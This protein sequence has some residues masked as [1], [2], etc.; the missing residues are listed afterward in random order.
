[1]PLFVKDGEVYRSALQCGAGL[2]AFLEF[3]LSDEPIDKVVLY[4]KS[5]LRSGL[6]DG[7]DPQK[8]KEAAL[9]GVQMANEEYG[10]K[11]SIKRLGYVPNDSRHYQLHKR[12]AFGI[13]KRIHEAGEFRHVGVKG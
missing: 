10:T 1:M 3:E 5:P 2:D 11:Y 6:S 8:I 13:I 7:V 9:L 4:E 12:I